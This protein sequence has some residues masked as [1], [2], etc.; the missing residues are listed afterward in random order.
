MLDALTYVVAPC[1][2]SRLPKMQICY[3]LIPGYT[4]MHSGFSDSG[5]KLVTA[6]HAF[7]IPVA[8]FWKKLPQEMEN[9]SSVEIF[10]VQLHTR[11][12]SLFPELPLQSLPPYSLQH[13]LHSTVSCPCDIFVVC[14]GVN[15]RSYCSQHQ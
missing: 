8:P 10:N 9:A 14:M 1:V 4:V 11:C 15:R 2:I 5:V 3:P 7:S 12:Q 6:K 13:L